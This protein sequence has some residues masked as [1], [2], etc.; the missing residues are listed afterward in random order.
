MSLFKNINFSVLRVQW[1][2]EHFQMLKDDLKIDTCHVCLPIVATNH[3]LIWERLS[4]SSIGLHFWGVPCTTKLLNEECADHLWTGNFMLILYQK[5]YI[6]LSLFYM[7]KL[8]SL[9]LKFTKFIHLEKE[10]TVELKVWKLTFLS[11]ASTLISLKS[12][13]QATTLPAC[14]PNSMSLT[15]CASLRWIGHSCVTFP[16]HTHDSLLFI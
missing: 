4:V 7:K 3:S 13:K 10:K 2:C 6:K 14:P 16:E 1:Y 5:I 9:V 11:L 15:G 8:L 12:Q